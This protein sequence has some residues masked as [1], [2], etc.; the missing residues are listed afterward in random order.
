MQV[1]GVSGQFRSPPHP[2]PQIGHLSRPVWDSPS[3][4]VPHQPLQSVPPWAPQP[5]PRLH[6]GPCPSS[7]PS[8]RPQPG[9]ETGT[10]VF[11][12]CLQPGWSCRQ[13]D[14]RRLSQQA[15]TGWACQSARELNHHLRTP[16]QPQT[17]WHCHCPAISRQ[18]R[19]Q[20]PSP[21][22]TCLPGAGGSCRQARARVPQ[23]ALLAHPPPCSPPFSGEQPS[24]RPHSRQGRAPWTPS[25]RSEGRSGRRGQAI[26]SG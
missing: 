5:L 7:G 20:H 23:R 14:R 1:R 15:A 11:C 26:Q 9:L 22:A 10:S 25:R 2:R 17:P 19:R 4:S 12:P 24:H 21:S 16:R 6:R 3:A 13:P 18:P 8:G